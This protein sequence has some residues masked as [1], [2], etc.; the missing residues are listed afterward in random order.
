VV[1]RDGNSILDRYPFECHKAASMYLP[2]SD[3]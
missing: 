1:G 3:H 2:H